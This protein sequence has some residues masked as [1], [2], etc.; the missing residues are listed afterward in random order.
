MTCMPK[1]LPKT[2]SGPM[3]LLQP[4]CVLMSMVHVATEGQTD[5]QD[6]GLHFLVPESHTAA[7]PE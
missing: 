1:L 5:A 3:V 2:M 7:K 4:E 6:L